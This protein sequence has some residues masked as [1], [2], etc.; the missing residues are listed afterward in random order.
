MNKHVHFEDESTLS[1]YNMHEE[2]VEVPQIFP[3]EKV[4]EDPLIQ[5]EV[6]SSKLYRIDFPKERSA[7]LYRYRIPGKPFPMSCDTIDGTCWWD[8]LIGNGCSII[9]DPV[10]EEDLFQADVN[11]KGWWWNLGYDDENDQYDECDELIQ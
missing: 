5:Q 3:V 11:Y 8:S 6:I 1:D 7:S 4:D 9:C 2:V 10:H